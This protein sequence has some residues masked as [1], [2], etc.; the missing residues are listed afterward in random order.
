MKKKIISF[1]LAAAMLIVGIPAFAD[2]TADTM[3][4]FDGVDA[5][6]FADKNNLNYVTTNG[7]GS[8]NGFGWAKYENVDFGSDGISEFIVNVATPGEFAGNKICFYIESISEL[9]FAELKVSSTGDWDNHKPQKAEIKDGDI[10]GIHNVYVSIQTTATGNIKNFYAVS[11]NGDSEVKVPQSVIKGGK[12]EIFKILTALEI[13]D[14]DPTV[15]FDADGEVKSGEFAKA[16]LMLRGENGDE[17][18]NAVLQNAGLKA[19]EGINSEKACQILLNMLNRQSTVLDG[20]SNYETAASI[21]IK[22]SAKAD[23]PLLWSEALQL[24]YDATKVPPLKISSIVPDKDGTMGTYTAITDNTL[25]IEY[26]N[27]H[28]SKGIL[29]MDYQTGLTEVSDIGEDQVLINNYIFDIGDCN[30]S[31]LLGYEVEYYFEATGY[32]NVLL[33][34]QKSKSNSITEINAYDFIDCKANTVRYWEG[35]KERN[36]KIPDS[37]S[38]IYNGIATSKCTSDMFNFKSGS[39]ELI[40]N[41]RDDVPDVVKV[42]NTEDYKFIGYD[43]GIIYLNDFDDTTNDGDLQIQYNNP[44]YKIGLTSVAGNEKEPK[45]LTSGSIITLATANSIDNSF[46]LYNM[47]E[48]KQTVKGT[49]KGLDKNSGNVRIEDKEYEISK[50]YID[51]GVSGVY[52]GATVKAYLNRYGEV[53]FVENG[54]SASNKLGFVIRTY[55]DEDTDSP[56][57]K[58]FDEDGKIAD[59]RCYK[60]IEV[61]GIKGKTESEVYAYIMPKQEICV[62]TTNR[63]GEIREITFPIEESP[64]ADKTHGLYHYKDV[65][66]TYADRYKVAGESLKGGEV[67]LNSEFTLFKIPSDLT[68]YESY[69]VT[70]NNFVEDE[71]VAVKC[72]NRASGELDVTIGVQIG[73]TLDN[74]TEPYEDV[75]YVNKVREEWNGDDIDVIIEYYNGTDQTLKTAIVSETARTKGKNLVPG[76]AI[77]FRVGTDGKLSGIVK[78]FS[79]AAGGSVTGPTVHINGGYSVIKNGNVA[80]KK[81][82]LIKLTGSEEVF[83]LTSTVFYV[84]E[85]GEFKIGSINDIISAESLGLGSKVYLY[86]KYGG[87]LSTVI[88]K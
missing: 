11:S 54:A 74:D 52:I 28:K 43:N 58:I 87:V 24:L 75:K 23:S 60:N 22:C 16:A 30:V 19:D 20:S 1:M 27:I 49:V 62:F 40:S 2:E 9:P 83:K 13:I 45:D 67:V 80:K 68:E 48:S 69:Q 77:R 64:T 5:S 3:S 31:G 38:I 61:D 39:L 65:A 71:E 50:D 76:D 81:N 18:V 85:D 12:E 6:K 21:D 84:F 57:I 56:I 55:M 25:L 47:W 33:Y 44:M 82:N 17:M 73:S 10:F 78:V 53:V 66:A 70:G 36:V 37:A 63:L 42:W 35:Q 15:G 51:R 8:S 7:L 14:Y 79:V 32:E 88:V 34:I 26:R 41:N 4:I 29:N 59:Y 86:T 46:V 72:Y